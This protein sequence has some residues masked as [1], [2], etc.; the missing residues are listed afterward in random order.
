[1]VRTTFRFIKMVI[2]PVILALVVLAGCQNYGRELQNA[3]LTGLDTY[4]FHASSTL[5]VQLDLN[6]AALAK[7]GKADQDVYRTFREVSVILAEHARLGRDQEYMPGA[8]EMAG[9]TVPFAFERKGDKSVLFIE[10]AKMPIVFQDGAHNPWTEI[11]VTEDEIGPPPPGLSRE[12][13][14]EWSPYFSAVANAWLPQGTMVF[15]LSEYDKWRSKRIDQIRV[16]KYQKLRETGQAKSLG[17]GRKIADLPNHYAKLR[18]SVRDLMKELVALTPL[19]STS[20]FDEV[21]LDINGKPERLTRLRVQ[22]NHEGLAEMLYAV[23]AVFRPSERRSGRETRG[24]S[25]V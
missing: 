12:S 1:M 14:W 8:L 24:R 11:E 16:Q 9:L 20:A 4:S 15:K 6:E 5:T 17:Y 25:V 3:F 13:S 21:V 19:P 7:M 22:A 23:R 18:P 2:A 10:G